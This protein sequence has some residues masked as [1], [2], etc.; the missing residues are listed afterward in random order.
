MADGLMIFSKKELF[1]Q[2][3]KNRYLCCC[4][5]D[6]DSRGYASKYEFIVDVETH[7][8]YVEAMAILESDGVKELIGIYIECSTNIIPFS[9]EEEVR[10]TPAEEAANFRAYY[11]LN[12]EE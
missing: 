1:E 12:K 11:G 5:V 8:E 9:G 3:P 7:E 2:L 6:R 10:F 4:V